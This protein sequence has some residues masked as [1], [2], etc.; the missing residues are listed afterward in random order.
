MFV[1]VQI[2]REGFLEEAAFDAALGFPE[3]RGTENI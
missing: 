3:I 2:I 1:K